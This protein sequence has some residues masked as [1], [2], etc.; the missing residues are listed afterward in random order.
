MFT[1]IILVIGLD[2]WSFGCIELHFL[3]PWKLPWSSM[4]QILNS[5]FLSSPSFLILGIY[6]MNPWF[7]IITGLDFISL[8]YSAL[9]KLCF[10]TLKKATGMLR[11]RKGDGFS[12]LYLGSQSRKI[13]EAPVRHKDILS[14]HIWKITHRTVTHLRINSFPLWTSWP[15]LWP[16]FLP[17]FFFVLVLSIMVSICCIP[18]P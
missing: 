11:V 1:W 12:V 10:V 2:N 14:C 18:E 5:T 17:T 8:Y 13:T 15:F 6:W 16:S 4:G 7:S 9:C 3:L